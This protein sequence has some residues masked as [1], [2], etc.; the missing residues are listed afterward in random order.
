MFT[1][2]LAALPDRLR[3]SGLLSGTSALALGVV[4][5]ALAG[6]LLLPLPLDRP[7]W[8]ATLLLVLGGMLAFAGWNLTRRAWNRPAWLGLGLGAAAVALTGPGLA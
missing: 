2:I 8:Q 7:A 4:A 3:G 1:T 5:V 6:T